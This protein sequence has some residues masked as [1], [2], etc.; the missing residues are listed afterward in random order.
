MDK[1]LKMHSKQ[2]Q[3]YEYTK[4]PLKYEFFSPNKEESFGLLGIG[5]KENNVNINNVKKTSQIH[6]Y[7]QSNSIIDAQGKLHL[8]VVEYDRLKYSNEKV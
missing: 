4:K 2:F 7:T 3:K 5:I 6:N 1:N 8:N